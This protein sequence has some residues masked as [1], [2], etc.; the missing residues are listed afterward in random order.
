[1]LA[2]PGMW[3]SL[4]TTPVDNKGNIPGNRFRHT[5]A[6]FQPGGVYGLGFNLRLGDLVAVPA[7]EGVLDKTSLGAEWRY[8]AM[9]NGEQFQ[10]YTGS[11][12]F[13]W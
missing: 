7:T 10:Q 8:N 4:M 11:L 12:A 6:D 2:G 5:D 9:A 13:G 1:M 3:I